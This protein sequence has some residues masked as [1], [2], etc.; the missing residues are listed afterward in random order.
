MVERDQRTIESNHNLTP[1]LVRNGLLSGDNTC[2]TFR[3]GIHI[4]ATY[5][6]HQKFLRNNNAHTAGFLKL[7]VPDAI[8][9]LTSSVFLLRLWML[10]CDRSLSVCSFP[11]IPCFVSY[12]SN[13]S[14]FHFPPASMCVYN[15]YLGFRDAN[16][17]VSD[18]GAL[19][20]GW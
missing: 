19:R 3:K 1:V 5:H 18:P 20:Q 11:Q 2:F 8:K 12:K 9:I 7:P 15:M 14:Y 4:K 6:V 13:Y 17:N 16:G 10:K